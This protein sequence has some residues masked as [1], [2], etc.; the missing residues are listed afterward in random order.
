[1]LRYSAGVTNW[2]QTDLDEID[3]KTR[4]LM[5]IYGGLHPKSDVHRLYLPRNCGGRGLLNVK[6]AVTTECQAISHYIMS[7]SDQPLLKEVQSR[8]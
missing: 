5:T 7:H 4:K 2:T 6:H 1:V 8:G 3:C